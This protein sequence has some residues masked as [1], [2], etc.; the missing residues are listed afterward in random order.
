MAD[1]II[2]EHAANFLLVECREQGEVL[3]NRKLQK[4]L[5]YAQAWYLALENR[6]LFA[7]DFQAWASPSAEILSPRNI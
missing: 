1:I 6:A 3:T 7:E 5:Y 2:P 4:L